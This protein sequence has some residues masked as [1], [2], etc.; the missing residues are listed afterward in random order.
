[1]KEYP[2]TFKEYIK[3][4]S[5][6]IVGNAISALKVERGTEIDQHDIVIRFNRGFLKCGKNLGNKCS[7]LVLG[8]PGNPG[9]YI[10]MPKFQWI[11]WTKS[12][13]SG[14]RLIPDIQKFKNLI[15]YDLNKKVELKNILTMY[16]SAGIMGL[17][18][19]LTCGEYKS[20]KIYGFDFSRTGTS[21][22]G[23][24]RSRRWHVPEA[25]EK[26][27]NNILLKY[28]NIT[29]ERDY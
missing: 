6:A 2:G 3:D 7:I 19:L 28:S 11:V 27:V 8:S 24:D 12:E 13:E 23:F 21:Y 18:L 17:D 10:E 5:I 16:P 15:Y 22:W 20:I 4:K 29:L 1:M 25:E 14:K 26:Y 9:D